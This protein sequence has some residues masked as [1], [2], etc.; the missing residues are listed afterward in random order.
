MPQF[1]EDF[2]TR[3]RDNRWNRLEKGYRAIVEAT[4]KTNLSPI[5]YIDSN[6]K[7]EIFDE[8]IEPVA[9]SEYEGMREG[10]GVIIAN[11]RADR[12]REI[13]KALGDRDFNE[14]KRDYIPLNSL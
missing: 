7:K 12:V 6:Y 8:F 13:T 11:F 2:I 5:E 14:F 1:L 3:D 9:F 4:P 10:D